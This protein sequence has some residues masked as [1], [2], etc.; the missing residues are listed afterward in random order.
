TVTLTG[1]DQYGNQLNLTDTTDADGH[2]AFIDLAA[3]NYTVSETQPAGYLDGKDSVGSA[4]G[5]L[6]NDVVSGISRSTDNGNGVNCNF[7]ELR[8][9]SLS[10]SVY[11]DTNNNGIRE[12]GEAGIGGVTVRLTGIDDLGNTVSLTTVTD[13]SGS[14]S[15][16]NLRA[17]MYQIT[18]I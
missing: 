8:P 4:G 17:G 15:F 3:G 10:G 1:T 18:E 13:G 9:S 11:D 5:T 14:Y 6:G 2:Y 12:G 16:Q 7:G